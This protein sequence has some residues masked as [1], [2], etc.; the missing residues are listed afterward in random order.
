MYEIDIDTLQ[1]CQ[2]G[3]KTAFAKIFSVYWHKIYKLMCKYSNNAEDSEDLTQETFVKIYQKIHTFRCE[4]SFETWL[5]R[6]AVNNALNFTR[7][8]H[9]TLSLNEV[10]GH[11][12][13]TLEPSI[14]AENKELS[15]RI[16]SAIAKLPEN[17][18]ITFVLVAIEGK[19]YADTAQIL[20]LNIDAVRMRMSR[21]RKQLCA[22]LKPYLC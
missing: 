16:Q 15:D 6:V 8:K 7:Q 12:K 1:L 2:R 14:D 5:Y 17:L 18:R 9:D 22:M 10:E 11:A 4:S 13:S 3:D 20:D 21:A 19:S